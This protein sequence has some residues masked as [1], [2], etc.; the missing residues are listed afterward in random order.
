MRSSFR[1]ICPV[2]KN[3]RRESIHLAIEEMRKN[4]HRPLKTKEHTFPIIVKHQQAVDWQKVVS[5]WVKSQLQATLNQSQLPLVLKDDQWI[6]ENVM[7]LSYVDN[8]QECSHMVK[9][10]LGQSK[11][12]HIFIGTHTLL[13]QFLDFKRI[14]R[15]V[16]LHNTAKNNLFWN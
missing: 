10:F 4:N 8:W 9:V 3:H 14:Y 13:C 12:C 15:S 11:K 7:I 6:D 16:S 2:A 5:Q 1:F